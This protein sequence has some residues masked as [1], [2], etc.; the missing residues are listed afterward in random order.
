[1]EDVSS[2]EYEEG[3]TKKAD[4]SN[5]EDTTVSIEPIAS[6]DGEEH[7][8]FMPTTPQPTSATTKTT[9]SCKFFKV[10]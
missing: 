8:M 7:S 10:F 4:K 6:P 9:V 2:V 3:G 5:H 1:M